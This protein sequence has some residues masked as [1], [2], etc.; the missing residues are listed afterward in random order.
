MIEHDVAQGSAEWLALR[1]G[2]PTASE[3][4]KIITP[5]KAELSKQARG[6]AFKLVAEICL[7]RSLDSLEGLEW[8]ERGKLLEPDAVRMYEFAEGVKTRAIGFITTDDGRIGASPDRLV[9]GR[10][11]GIELKCPAPQT[12]IEYMIDGFGADY[13]AQVQGQM[14]VGELGCVH[15]YSFH[16][17]MPPVLDVVPRDEEYIKKLAAA[18][19]EFC[20]MKDAML[21]KARASGF[22]VEREAVTGPIDEAYDGSLHDWTITGDGELVSPFAAG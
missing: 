5:A 12:H 2:I 21:E 9:I 15:R 7:N 10:P 3:F 16:P 22:F 20:D 6:Y 18:L 1:I 11:I 17:E 13:R 19:S 4:K 14:W 8:I